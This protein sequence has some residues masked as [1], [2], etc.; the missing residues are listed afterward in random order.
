MD[1]LD[2]LLARIREKYQEA[3]KQA[4]LAEMVP[5]L[6]PVDNVGA[7]IR[8]ERK[9]QKL[10]LHDLCSLSDVSYSTLSKLEKGNPSARLNVLNR[11]LNALGLKLWVG[12]QTSITRGA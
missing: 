9:K 4:S 5:N 10:T 3:E 1:E 8:L 11:V 2:K 12:S 6:M 7:L